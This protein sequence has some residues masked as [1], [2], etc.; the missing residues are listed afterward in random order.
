LPLT[1]ENTISAGSAHARQKRLPFSGVPDPSIAK[2]RQ[3]RRQN[4]H[5]KTIAGMIGRYHHTGRLWANECTTLPA[6]CPK[7][8][9]LPNPLPPASAAAA[10]DPFCL[11]SGY[12]DAAG[13]SFHYT[14]VSGAGDLHGIV[15]S[16]SGTVGKLRTAA[17]YD[18]SVTVDIKAGDHDSASTV[19]TGGI[20]F[21]PLAAG[22]TTVSATAV[23][24]GTYSGSSQV[25]TVNP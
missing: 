2:P 9:A 13:T 12:I 19:A 20:A 7:K 8:T 6:V 24:F 14:P 18:A 11:R 15:T 21:D 16:S 1:S 4:S 17:A 3:A 22:T 5:G 10:D 23:G 25:V